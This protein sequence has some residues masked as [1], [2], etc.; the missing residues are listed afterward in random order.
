MTA[1][2][3]L[4]CHTVDDNQA[5]PARDSAHGSTP[6]GATTVFVARQPIL[7]SRGRV[8]GYE[9]LYRG[10]PD[11]VVCDE[12]PDRAGARI[13]TDVLRD[14]LEALTN[15]RYAFVNATRLLLVEELVTLLPAEGVVIEVLETVEPDAE[16]L[17]VCRRLRERGY[18]LALDDF[19]WDDRYCDLLAIADFVKVDV[20][21]TTPAER[22]EIVARARPHGLRLIAE[23]IETQE[24]YAEALQAG[25][26]YF[27]GFFFARPVTVQA[28]EI[29]ASALR[30]VQ[31]LGALNNPSLAAAQLADLIK[32]DVSLSFRVLRSVNSAATMVRTPVHSIQQAVV[33]LGREQIRRWASVWLLAG[34]AGG[35][36]SPTVTMSL[37]RARWC[38]LLGTELWGEEAGREL[39]LCGMISLLDAILGR[40]MDALVAALP[41]SDRVRAA[42][43]GWPSPWTVLLAS[44]AAYEKGAWDDAVA[45]AKSIGLSPS[46]LAA[47]H[48]QALKWEQQTERELEL[49]PRRP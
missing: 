33:L 41:L 12:D 21:A 45:S 44:L 2:R 18:R 29:P 7:D 14:G 27:Q 4:E 8:F 48:L 25:F 9:L 34:V 35:L 17:E 37:V 23:K 40:P 3:V 16:I 19:A 28:R 5:P 26:T 39:F 32:Q 22:A 47:T 30:H 6:P 38:E 10:G 11:A 36:P 1:A 49:T 43:C 20:L 15:G 46:T 42:L 31:L 13:F 24:A